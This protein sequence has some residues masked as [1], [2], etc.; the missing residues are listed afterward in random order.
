M[1]SGRSMGECSHAEG[2]NTAAHGLASHAE[3]LQ[4]QAKGVFSHAEG[5]LTTAAGEGAHAEGIQTTAEGGA[6][7]GEGLK[8]IA[9]GDM[10][11]AEGTETNANGTASH[12]EGQ[13]TT[14][15]GTA[16]HAEGQSTMAK[17]E[18]SHAEGQSTAAH[19][20]GSHAE[21]METTANGQPSHAEGWKTLA[22]GFASHAEGQATTAAVFFF[23]SRRRHTISNGLCSHTEGYGTITTTRY[24]HAEGEH[25]KAEGAASHAEGSNTTAGG[26]ASH[27]EGARTAAGGFAA[28]A[29]G[30]E[31]IADGHFSHGEGWGTSTG[32]CEGAHIMGKFGDADEPYS[33]YLANGISAAAK[34]IAAKIIGSAGNMFIDGLYGSSGTSYAEMFESI[35][36]KP[37]D[38]GYFVTL[39]GKKIRRANEKDAYIL[40]V[41]VTKPAILASCG[42]LRWKGK[43]MT[44]PWQ[45]IQYREVVVPEVKDGN[46]KVILPERKEIQP[47]IHPGWDMTRKYIPRRKRPEWI[48]VGLLGQLLVRDDGTCSENGY[49]R[50]NPSGI[51]TAAPHG[52]RVLERIKADQILILFR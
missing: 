46:G 10:S 31:V 29:Q 34:G 25:T 40:G 16:S 19:G 4:T 51:A 3:G 24:A 47:V 1:C 2:K 33:W 17:G 23:S 45:R 48:P 11:H 30:Y 43:Y 49:C 44:D 8:T 18:A 6:S 28:H 20:D 27:A 42:E 9:K 41:T 50:V 12:S 7:H 5:L 37:I 39:H 26:F 36:G 22:Q 21:G 52:Y 13:F 32:L 14:A 38:P 15:Y 35:D